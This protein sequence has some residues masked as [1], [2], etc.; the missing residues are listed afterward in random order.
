[1]K[2]NS[3]VARLFSLGLKGRNR[4]MFIE[5]NVIYSYGMHFPI[6]VRGDGVAIINNSKWSV[7]T[8]RHQNLVKHFLKE[9]GYILIEYT[10][11]E[12]KRFIEELDGKSFTLKDLIIKKL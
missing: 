11:F 12:I 1:M 7:S 4:N 10:I 5:G 2:S 8:S 9:R 6:A 3:E